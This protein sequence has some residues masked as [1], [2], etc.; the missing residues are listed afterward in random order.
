MRGLN[1][2]ES[3]E[4]IPGL[5]DLTERL[6]VWSVD[7]NIKLGT[8]VFQN[9]AIKTVKLKHLEKGE[10]KKEEVYDLMIANQHEYFANGVLVHNCIDALRYGFDEL[11]QD[12]Q[13]Y[14]A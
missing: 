2:I 1:G 12:N 6:L 4:K 11:M 3:K 14:F 8:Q 7:Q 13:F 10:S 9:F 5:I